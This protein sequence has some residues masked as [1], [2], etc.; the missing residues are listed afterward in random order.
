MFF[1]ID[2]K[3]TLAPT[4]YAM[5][6][7][8]ELLPYFTTHPA[9]LPKLTNGADL[10][11]PGVVTQGTGMNVY[12]RYKKD[13]L[14][15]VNL[16][17]NRAAVGVGI[18]P[19]SSDDMYMSGGHGAAVKMLHLFGDK[20]WGHEPQLVQQVPNLRSAPLTK[21][22]FPAL[23]ADTKKSKPTVSTSPQNLA[24]IVAQTTE[25]QEVST[26]FKFI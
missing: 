9:V 13:Q 2:E 22:D 5:W 14:V 12:G 23:G 4:L 17:S 6:L 26:A 21:D 16:T 18:L 7:V 15:G 8:P 3:G 1:E 19:R 25:T 10:M 11:L 20:L 24:E